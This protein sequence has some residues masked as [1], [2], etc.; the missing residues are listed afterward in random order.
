MEYIF[1][2]TSLTPFHLHT[3]CVLFTALVQCMLLMFKQSGCGVLLPFNAL[4]QEFY[5]LIHPFLFALLVFALLYLD[6]LGILVSSLFILLGANWAL[7]FNDGLWCFDIVE[8][9]SLFIVFALL[10]TTHTHFL[11]YVYGVSFAIVEFFRFTSTNSYHVFG[12]GC[13]VEPNAFATPTCSVREVVFIICSLFIQQKLPI[14]GLNRM[15]LL[16]TDRVGRLRLYHA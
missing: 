3:S 6:I 8:V 13:S 9:L 14:S 5:S 1:L 15:F 2:L 12:G 16:Y 4:G 11:I 10:L 7:F